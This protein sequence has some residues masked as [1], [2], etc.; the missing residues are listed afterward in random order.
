MKEFSDYLAKLPK[1]PLVEAVQ[2][3]Y[4]ASERGEPGTAWNDVERIHVYHAADPSMD[5]DI[6]L[7]SLWSTRQKDSATRQ[8]VIDRFVEDAEDF[9]KWLATSEDGGAFI[10]TASIKFKCDP[11]EITVRIPCPGEDESGYAHNVKQNVHQGA[12]PCN[13]SL[14]HEDFDDGIHY[15][16]DDPDPF[17][18]A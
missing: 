16:E 9:N 7:D 5:M 2:S 1:T 17:Q 4:E 18:N 11:N 12:A 3:L 8:E 15:S 13:N 6:K 10:T 14:D